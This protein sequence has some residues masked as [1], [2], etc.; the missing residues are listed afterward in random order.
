MRGFDDLSFVWK[1][2]TYTL[3]SNKTLEAIARVE[4]IITLHELQRYSNKASTPLGKLS[5]AYGA[6]LRFVGVKVSDVEIYEAMFGIGKDADPKVIAESVI[7]LISMMVP[8]AA[9]QSAKEREVGKAIAAAAAET[10]KGSLNKRTSL[11]S[12]TGK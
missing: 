12:R 2:V 1:G 9:M 5:M 8:P 3:P 10:A 11:R 4:D 7:T 6:L